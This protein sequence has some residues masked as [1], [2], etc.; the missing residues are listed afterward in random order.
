MGGAFFVP[1]NVSPTAEFN[2]WYDP[3]AAKTMYESG[4][5]IVT[6]PLDITTQTIFTLKDLQPILKYVNNEL[7]RKFLTKLTE[8]TIGTNTMFRETNYRR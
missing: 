6:A 3:A 4:A 2:V 5:N 8:F 7:Y 1:G